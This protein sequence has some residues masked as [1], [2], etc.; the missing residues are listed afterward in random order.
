VQPEGYAGRVLIGD[1]ERGVA[2]GTVDRRDDGTFEWRINLPVLTAA[3]NAGRKL[4]D[5]LADWGKR[6]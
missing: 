4:S 2:A 6:P 1:G 5:I 3:I